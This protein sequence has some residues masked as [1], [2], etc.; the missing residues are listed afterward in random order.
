MSLL[1][2]I[3]ISIYLKMFFKKAMVAFSNKEVFGDFR[4]GYDNA[5][6]VVSRLMFMRRLDLD[7]KLLLD[8]EEVADEVLNIADLWSYIYYLYYNNIEHFEMM[9]SDDG[10]A[11]AEK[12]YQTVAQKLNI[13]YDPAKVERIPANQLVVFIAKILEENTLVN[14]IVDAS[15]KIV[16]DHTQYGK[17]VAVSLKTGSKPGAVKVVYP[18]HPEFKDALVYV[19]IS[20]VT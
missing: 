16:E 6:A 2:E 13:S 10:K 18:D 20:K 3:I 11:S 14:P 12:F 1:R 5:Y 17:L 7:G 19:T 15:R 4:A 9:K 8:K